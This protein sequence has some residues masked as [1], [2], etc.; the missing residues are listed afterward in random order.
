[1]VCSSMGVIPLSIAGVSPAVV[2]ASCLAPYA[3]PG[4]V[5]GAFPP[6]RRAGPLG[7]LS[8]VLRPFSLCPRPS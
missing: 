1:M 4:R 7:R 2:W 5:C 3:R 6:F 8:C